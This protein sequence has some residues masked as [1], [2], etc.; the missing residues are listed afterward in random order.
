MFESALEVKDEFV[1]HYRPMDGPTRD[2]TSSLRSTTGSV[3]TKKN[4][5][6]AAFSSAANDEECI[7][8]NWIFSMQ[9]NPLH[10]LRTSTFTHFG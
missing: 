9:I 8:E 4:M 2:I 7:Y 10:L 5:A 3:P 6:Y 1:D